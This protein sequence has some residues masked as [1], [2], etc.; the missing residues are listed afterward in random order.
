MHSFI[1]R[2]EAEASVKRM[3]N[4]HADAAGAVSAAP[5]KSDR[6]LNLNRGFFPHDLAAGPHEEPREH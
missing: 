2:I 3:T 5:P 6:E 4:R 1:G